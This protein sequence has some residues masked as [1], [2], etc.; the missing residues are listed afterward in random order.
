MTRARDI[1]EAAKEAADIPSEYFESKRSK[2]KSYDTVGFASSVAS[3]VGA[4]A[5]GVASV[6]SEAAKRI[7]KYKI[8]GTDVGTWDMLVPEPINATFDWGL[9]DREIDFN[10]RTFKMLGHGIGAMAG[11]M[12]G[13]FGAF[14]GSQIVGNFFAFAWENPELFEPPGDEAFT[15]F[16]TDEAFHGE[17]SYKNWNMGVGEGKSMLF[18][19]YE[20]VFRA[21]WREYTRHGER[22]DWEDD[23]RNPDYDDSREPSVYGDQLYIDYHVD[24]SKR[25]C[26]KLDQ[27][28]AKKYVNCP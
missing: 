17:Q 23:P 10:F 16:V 3:G 26:Y 6:A 27:Y 24:R 13:P 9:F 19:V 18:K 12:F 21:P 1:L 28:G 14:V 25:R 7:R 11:A 15:S 5:A 20:D 4:V 2:E 22:K 8:P